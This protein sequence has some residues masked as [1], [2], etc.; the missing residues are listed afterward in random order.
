MSNQH[1]CLIQPSDATHFHPEGIYAKWYKEVDG[2]WH[3]WAGI[4]FWKVSLNSHSQLNRLI[5][6]V[7]L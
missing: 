3:Y 4:G 5:S 1:A 6:V 2:V 7:D